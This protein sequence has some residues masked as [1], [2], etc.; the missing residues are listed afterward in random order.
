MAEMSLINTPEWAAVIKRLVRAEMVLHDV[1][2]EELSNRLY[3][4]FNT[5]QTVSNLKAKINKGVLGAQLL[6]QIL[7]VLETE[8]LDIPR[9]RRMFDEINK[10]D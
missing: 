3:A 4:H 2:Y 5:V 8:S 10:A 6:V 1:T 9:I 7:I